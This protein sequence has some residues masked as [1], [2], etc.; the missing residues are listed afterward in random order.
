MNKVEKSIVEPKWVKIKSMYEAG[1][2]GSI[3]YGTN[4]KVGGELDM[5]C[6]EF[7]D[8]VSQITIKNGWGCVVEEI[9]MD[10][11][12]ERIWSLIENAGL[13]PEIAWRDD[14]E[15]TR[16]KQAENDHWDSEDEFEY[17]FEHN[18]HE[19]YNIKS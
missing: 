18:E 16:A 15:T 10:L 2:N 3:K 13:L 11:W 5:L 4:F 19:A 12:K 7:I 17:E 1:T 14:K 8:M 9:K 6:C